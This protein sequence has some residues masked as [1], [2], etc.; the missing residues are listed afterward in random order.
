MFICKHCNIGF[1]GLSTANKANHTRWCL[2]NPKRSEYIKKNS[3]SQLQTPES[4]A[5]RSLGIKRAHADGKYDGSAKKGVD[6]KRANGN[7]GHTEASK[8]LI[9]QKALAS[10]HRRLLRSIRPYMCVDGTIVMLDSSW[11]EALAK[12]L[13]DVGIKWIRPDTPI[14]YQSKDGVY[15]NYFPDFYLVDYNLYLDPKNPAALA[16]QKEKI[17]ILMNQMDN[18]IIIENLNECE[19]FPT[20]SVRRSY[21]NG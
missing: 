1:E 2:S 11:E 3:G 14:R 15:H 7:I 16:A 12:R 19:Q 8:E 13:D 18:L 21:F 20:E 4:I 5:K 10:N 17:D 6:T 9:R